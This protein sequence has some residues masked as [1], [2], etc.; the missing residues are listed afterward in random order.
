[1]STEPTPALGW[2][3]V[4]EIAAESSVSARRNDLDHDRDCLRDSIRRNGLLPEHPIL[5]RP[6]P[7]PE[8]S[9][10]QYEVVAGQRRLRAARA[11]G[12]PTIPAVVAELDDDAAHRRSLAENDHR[13]ALAYS[14]RIYWYERRYQE[15]QQE[16]GSCDA[17]QMTAAYYNVSEGNVQ[18]RLGLTVLPSTDP[19]HQ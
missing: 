1:M 10:F 4:T 16:H 12:L 19:D 5:L 17:I 15:F 2:I 6:H 11:L 8:R 9:G 13:S 18:D 14:D 7:E 3:A